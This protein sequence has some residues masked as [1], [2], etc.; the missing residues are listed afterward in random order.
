MRLSAK[1]QVT[2]PKRV[3]EALGVQPGGEV[4]FHIEGSVV[5]LQR[6]AKD[7]KGRSRGDRLVESLRGTKSANLDMTTDQIMRLLRADD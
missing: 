3:R 7:R 4:D 1:S 6:G 5:T 2:V